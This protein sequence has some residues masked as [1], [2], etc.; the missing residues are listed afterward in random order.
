[1]ARKNTRGK[2][3][4]AVIGLGRFGGA[5]AQALT[6]LG[7][8]VLGIEEDMALVQAWSTRLR[9]VVQA[10]ATDEAVLRELGVDKM[11]HAIIAIGT[12]LEA[13]VLAATT[14]ADLGVP[15]IWAKA[16]TA[17]HGRLLERMGVHHVL[18]PEASM[19]ERV[20]HQIADHVLDYIEFGDGFTIAKV[21]VPPAGVGLSLADYALR[22]EYGITVVGVKRRGQDFEYARPETVIEEGNLLI[23]AGPTVRIQK[24]AADCGTP[25]P[26]E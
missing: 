15:D 7:H 13:S 9:H 8:D 5:A 6:N 11:E 2:Q 16:L 20:A 22:T 25:E 21:G 18:F 12:D 3:T 24:F 4:V 23:V 26:D 19:G 10:D 17:K 14:V 1:L